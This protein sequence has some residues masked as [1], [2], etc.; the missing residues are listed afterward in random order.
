MIDPQLNGRVALV[1]GANQGI[2]AAIAKALAAQGASVFIT[3]LR[4]G[5]DDPGVKATPLTAYGEARARDASAVVRVI[6]AA[7]G[8]A[9]SSEADLADPT[10]PAALFDRAEATFGPVD[11]LVNNADA[12]VG[13]SFVQDGV[14]SLGV[15]V[16]PVT[17][18]TYEHSFAVNVRAAA[19]LIVEFASRHRKRGATWGRIIGLTSG[20]PGGFPE[21]VSYGASKA[22]LDNY[23]QAAAKELGQF[24]IT[25][26]LL[27]PPATDTGWITEETARRIRAN[28]P[29][30]HVGM[31]E[32]VAE[33]AVFLAS[34]QARFITGQ[35]V[36]MS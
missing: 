32:E 9:A 12:W 16:V 24:G 36:R 17:K 5:V 25:A 15:G 31:P 33:V 11:I 6:E 22:A 4:L 27:Y 18:E 1:T 10:T 2:G 14:S 34:H 13:D 28:S 7:G 8:R 35:I 20:G 30:R 3:Y 26:N 23:T 21:Q 19:M 29:L